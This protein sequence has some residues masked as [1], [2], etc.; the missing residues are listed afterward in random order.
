MMQFSTRILVL[1]RARGLSALSVK[2]EFS[3]CAINAFAHFSKIPSHHSV[4]KRIVQHPIPIHTQPCKAMRFRSLAFDY[5]AEATNLLCLEQRE[6]STPT[7]WIAPLPP[8]RSIALESGN[9]NSDNETGDFEFMA[10]STDDALVSPGSEGTSPCPTIPGESSSLAHNEVEAASSTPTC[11]GRDTNYLPPVASSK[12][13]TAMETKCRD[14]GSNDVCPPETMKT[15]WPKKARPT[16][17]IVTDKK[18]TRRQRRDNDLFD[19]VDD[20]EVDHN[21]DFLFADGATDDGAP[22]TPAMTEAQD[23]MVSSS[24]NGFKISRP[25]ILTL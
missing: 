2:G 1:L 5:H 6:D 14:S 4:E 11:T 10:I 23:P 22:V 13:G 9:D 24:N 3:E 19:D 16:L 18:A 7:I 8:D 17:P 25:A 21:E 15:P 20:G 12:N